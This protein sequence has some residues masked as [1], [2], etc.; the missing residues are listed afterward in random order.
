MNQ[1]ASQS[2]VGLRI[3]GA[4][5]FASGLL[6]VALGFGLFH[7]RN[8]DPAEQAS[9]IVAALKLDPDNRYI[10]AAIEKVA[11]VSPRQLELI[12]LGTFLYASMYL[13]E[14]GG[15]LL[16][17]HWAEWLTVVATGFFI[18]L[19]IYEVYEKAT[20]IRIGLLFINV[21][22]VAYLVYQLKRQGAEKAG[23]KSDPAPST[24]GG[25]IT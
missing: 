22:I 8:A 5:K 9:H 23:A 12:S 7:G 13:V 24:G 6:L 19:E 14:G 18:P 16:R 1:P 15:L 11:G 4:F 20:P 2:P 25:S 10:H 21:A 3:I 17:K